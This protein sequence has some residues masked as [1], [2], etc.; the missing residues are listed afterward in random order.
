MTTPNERRAIDDRRIR[1]E[2]PP[3]GWMDRRRS[4]E[5]RI[6]MIDEYEVSEAEWLLYFGTAKPAETTVHDASAEILGRARD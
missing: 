2:G 1:D 3:L 4:T 6:P 5:R